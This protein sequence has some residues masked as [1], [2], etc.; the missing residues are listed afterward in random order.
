MSQ[1]EALVANVGSRLG[2]GPEA[3]PLVK[4]L[5][6]LVFGGPKGFEGF[7]DR[8]KSAGLG[9]LVASWIG[10]AD[11]PPLGQQGAAQAFG[12]ETIAALAEKVGLDR[13]VVTEA[14][15]FLAPKL[16]GLLTAGGAIPASAPPAVAAFLAGAPAA[17]SAP[18]VAAAPALNP[19]LGKSTASATPPSAAVSHGRDSTGLDRYFIPG[20]GALLAIGF[21]YHFV[22]SRPE[23]APAPAASETAAALTPAHFGFSNDNGVIT[24][25]GVVG[26]N[27]ARS[28]I[29]DAL[30]K[31]FGDKVSSAV[32]VEPNVAP[33]PWLAKLPAALELLKV[34]AL[35]ADFDGAKINLS[36]SVP[37]ADLEA[38][39]GKLKALFGGDFTFAAGS[40]AVSA[41]APS[42]SSPK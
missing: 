17:G 35:T 16:I 13:G 5:L 18:A 27:T 24:A 9:G 21:V 38:I 22:T 4:G 6:Q 10:Q 11:N 25:S 40:S 26:D 12:E 7:L 28:A 8:F 20:I 32:S 37:P 39:L 34:P 23:P 29:L 15:A 36:G 41:P 30:K 14:L 31:A 33:A 19:A 1:I 2:I 3:A 42:A